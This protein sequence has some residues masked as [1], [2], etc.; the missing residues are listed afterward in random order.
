LTEI[1]KKLERVPQGLAEQVIA[2]FDRNRDYLVRRALAETLTAIASD[3]TPQ[4]WKA[5]RQRTWLASVLREEL[6]NSLFAVFD[7]NRIE[8]LD[9]LAQLEKEPARPAGA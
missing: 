8:S 1:V 3:F 9:R 4:V 6:S 2:E 5:I 7:D